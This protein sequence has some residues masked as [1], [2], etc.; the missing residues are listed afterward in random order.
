MLL[1]LFFFQKSTFFNAVG[2]VLGDYTGYI[3][4]DVIT[5]RG[6]NDKAA[7]AT[8]RGKRLV[9]AGELEEGRRL[10]ASTIKKLSSTDP[11]VVEEK[12]KQPETV[13]PSHTL[14]LF[15]NHLPRVSSTDTG[16]WRRIIV[17]P[18]NAVIRKDSTIQNYADYLVKEAGG[19]ILA[20]AIEGA[21]N[22]ARNGFH[23]DIP[24]CVEE[25]TEAYRGRE[26]WL[27]NFINE[28]CVRETEATAAFA[29]SRAFSS[30][31]PSAAAASSSAFAC[32]ASRLRARASSS[33]RLDSS[34][35]SS[36]AWCSFRSQRFPSQQSQPIESV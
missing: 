30:F 3:D 21:Q 28:R 17:I 26:N 6:A 32:M 15:T 11:F 27:E 23:L 4:I 14:C 29:S 22:F 9:I 24:E 12:Y 19:A 18:F 36:S 5:T 8:L 7:L 2:A 34:S 1:L 20:W 31:W 25:A 33:I 35:A 10:S 13:T 16:T